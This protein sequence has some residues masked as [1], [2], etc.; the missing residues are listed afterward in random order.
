MA[1]KNTP[2]GIRSLVYVRVKGKVG[3][4]GLS[5]STGRFERGP[6]FA[7]FEPDLNQAERDGLFGRFLA[8]TDRQGLIDAHSLVS[9]GR[10]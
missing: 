5:M 1:G 10:D 8:V 4:E 2:A 6:G 3:I 7:G 9:D